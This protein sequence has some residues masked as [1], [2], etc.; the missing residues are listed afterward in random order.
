[1]SLFGNVIAQGLSLLATVFVLAVGLAVLAIIVMFVLDV[2]QRHDAI[3]RNY[4][5]IGRF[6]H[7]FS[8]LGEF[9]RQYFFA[10]D[11]EEMP[12]NR[13]QR[14]WVNKSS[15]GVD[16]T[17]AFGSTQNIT[18]PGSPIFASAIYAPL[19]AECQEPPALVIG[20]HAR[21]PYEARS[22][23]NISA[24]SYGA[25]SAPAIR[26][27]SQGA[28]MAGCWLNTGEGGLSDHHLSGGC[29]I[30]FQIGT[31]K[32]GVRTEQGHFSEEKLREVAARPQVRMIEVKLSQGAKPGK[33]GIL[34]AEK[35][36]PEISRVRG[37][38]E[39][40]ASISPNR[41]EEIAN[42]GDLL[43]FIARVR[44]VSGL[45]TGFKTAMGDVVWLEELCK[46]IIKRGQKS[47]PD[48]ITI[49]AGDGGTGA[50]PMPLIDNTALTIKEALPLVVGHAQQVWP[51]GPHPGDLCGQADHPGGGRVGLLC[52]CRLRQY[53]AR[54]HV[55]AGLHPVAQ[56]QQEHVPDRH[57]H[58]PASFAA[59][60]RSGRQGG[61]GDELRQQ[62][63]LWR[64]VDRPCLR[65]A[66]CARAGAPARAAGAARWQVGSIRH[67]LPAGQGCARQ[68]KG[69]VN[70]LPRFA[71]DRL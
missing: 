61:A 69:R 55:C 63:P 5:V 3:R 59:R 22:I 11:R 23:I 21:E 66:S 7:I 48:F 6:R 56:V 35:V 47:A 4:P 25:L 57:H 28:K 29:D 38:P 53:R 12:F 19:E 43:D 34:P 14:D 54:V 44:E 65:C 16:N 31:A 8:E 26:A 33:G 62:D 10:M 40:Q 68:G 45:P 41:H 1:M 2:S 36:T 17:V 50:A 51:E 20:P 52:R 67:A 42:H 24:M 46:L 15:A 27:L 37:I 71:L 18:A 64:G 13:A 30:V 60:A 32:Y 58:P 70:P 9:F 49:D 39:G